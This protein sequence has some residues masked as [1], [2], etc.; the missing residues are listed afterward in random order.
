M[1]PPTLASQLVNL[2]AA[3]LLLISF[4]MLSQRRTR[5]L[6]VLFALQGAIL[7]ASTTL[8][9]YSAGLRHLYYSAALTLGL[10]V[11][12]LPW[13]LLRRGDRLEAQWDSEPLIKIPTTML[14]GVG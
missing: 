11:F 8:V 9:A 12:F 14:I 10:K 6:I 13:V 4:A 2:F 1:P 5:R 3:G 7:V